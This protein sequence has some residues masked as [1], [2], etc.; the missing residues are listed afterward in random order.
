MK[1]KDTLHFAKPEWNFKELLQ[2]CYNG[3]SEMMNV[4]SYAITAMLFNSALIYYAG[5]NG[6]AAYSVSEYFTAVVV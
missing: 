2:T 4:I 1:Q 6:V 3:S 5:E